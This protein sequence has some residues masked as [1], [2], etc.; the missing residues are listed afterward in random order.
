MDP[1]T[2]IMLVEAIFA[3]ATAVDTSVAQGLA[4]KRNTEIS[5]NANELAKEVA[6]DEALAN[7]L[8][9]AYQMKDTELFQN[10]L[11]SSPFG[12]RF[13]QLK[14]EYQ[15]NKTDINKV[16][17]ELQRIQSEGQA[18]QTEMSNK[19]AKS[20]TSGEVI[21]DLISGRATADTS[22]PEYKRTDLGGDYAG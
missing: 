16:Q 21:A 11:N 5:K 9:S 12:S 10:L 22:K 4:N 20:Q 6:E 15:D 17:N 18:A 2:V 19:A 1:I 3:I 7:K 14:R 8:L 13:R